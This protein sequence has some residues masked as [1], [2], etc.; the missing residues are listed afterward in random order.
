MPPPH[1][2]V[3]IT[4]VSTG[5]GHAAA[6]LLAR[7]G[8]HVF[9][10]VREPQAAAAHIAEL[11]T[12]FTPLIFDVRDAAAVAAAASQVRTAL[13][14]QRLA[15][16]INN[17][18]IARPGPLALQP[19]ADFREQ[20]EVNL[21]APFRV[22]QAFLP[23]LGTDPALAGAPGRII[24]ISSVAGVKAVPFAGAYVAAKHGME[25]YSKTLALELKPF[26]IDVIVVAPG[27]VAT[28]I[29]S[30]VDHAFLA[31]FDTTPYAAPLRR[32]RDDALS[33][34]RAGIS[35]ES[36]AAVIWTALT[37]PQPKSRYPAANAGLARRALARFLP[38]N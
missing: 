18:G 34:E 31:G 19:A 14:S 8:V 22:T 13:G 25:G 3:V 29:W 26:G 37:A 2:A 7:N 16:L 15:A 24:N 35:P 28:P 21:V 1:R 38:R 9:G 10:S 6:R 27:T 32:F 30:K 11:G 23:L 5:I 20:I 4:G 33:N 36:A 12:F 17:A